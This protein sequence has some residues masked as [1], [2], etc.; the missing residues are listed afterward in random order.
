MYVSLY[1]YKEDNTGLAELLEDH[2]HS[3][4]CFGTMCQALFPRGYF[5]KV[6]IPY[7][8]SEFPF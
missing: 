3:T 8:S 7:F 1:I 5:S 2:I 6:D 4:V